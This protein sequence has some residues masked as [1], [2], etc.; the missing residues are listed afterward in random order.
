[1]DI[2][3]W[4][5]GQVV[6]SKDPISEYLKPSLEYMEMLPIWEMCRDAT[7]GAAK[8][9]AK[10]T[11]YLPPL[12][13]HQLDRS[14]K[15]TGMFNGILSIL[16]G[17]GSTNS[18]G[19]RRYED[20]KSRA[21]WYGAAGLT[22]DAFINMIFRKMPSYPV[23]ST[24]T[25]DA[26][27]DD[28]EFNK[29]FFKNASSYRESMTELLARLSREW[30]ET[31][32]VGLLEDRAV[33]SKK[34]FSVLY[35]AEQIQR[36]EYR[37][38]DE[39]YY[40]PDYYVL[41]EGKID[42][43]KYRM[44]LLDDMQ[45][46]AQVVFIPGKQKNTF[47]IDSIVKPTVFEEGS[48][49][50][51]VPFKQIPF[52]LF[53]ELKAP[54]IYDLT[55]MALGYYRNSAD[56]ENEQHMVSIKTA[57]FPGWDRDE[58]GEPALGGALTCPINTE[59]FIMEAKTESQLKEAMAEKVENCARLGSSIL[60]GRGKYLQAK[61]TAEINVGGDTCAVEAMSVMLQEKV[62]EILALKLRW[63][64]E[65]DKSI[66][67]SLNTQYFAT[68][69]D[70]N[71][72]ATLIKGMQSNALSFDTFFYVM[73]NGNMYPD[74]WTKDKELRAIEKNPLPDYTDSV[75]ESEPFAENDIGT[76][77]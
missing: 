28:M 10:G 53:G 14:S 52:W 8:I 25:G 49:S 55:E 57:V 36:V 37:I 24:V 72:I 26:V 3:T 30:L 12:D 69:L 46:Y 42:A 74:G 34:S 13:S 18:E 51:L 21:V 22:V 4:V 58:Y 9:K 64:G 20:Y 17:G 48:K 73:E 41:R 63:I 54:R 75:L 68:G 29:F 16:S 43:V 23:T 44:L 19:A 15:L 70:A 67:L 40:V 11:R 39:G 31:N 35:K 66:K 27:D 7:E 5:V 33:D 32:Y 1:M 61:E 59:P 77:I 65:F 2:S 38:D 60:S 47:I 56:R 45:E 76:N 71:Y 50:K 62:D 6:T